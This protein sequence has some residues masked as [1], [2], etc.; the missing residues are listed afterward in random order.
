MRPITIIYILALCIS[1]CGLFILAVFAFLPTRFCL[2][3]FGIVIL[4]ATAT[5]IACIKNKKIKRF[6]LP[7]LSYFILIS[8]VI[9]VILLITLL[10]SGH[11]GYLG[12]THAPLTYYQITLC[13]L[14]AKHI[15]PQK[16]ESLKSN[17]DDEF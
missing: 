16:S 5:I 13:I 7:I 2:Y 14:S 6:Y 9:H 10:A 15:L 8:A 3:S 11:A 4:Y 17:L 1:I 12:Y